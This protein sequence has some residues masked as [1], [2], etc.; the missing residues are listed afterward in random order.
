MVHTSADS[1]TELLLSTRQNPS[2]M[3]S[4]PAEKQNMQLTFLEAKVPLT[5]S[6]KQ[7]PDG[8]YK[9]GGYPG[10]TNFTS[11]T[12]T[13]ESA[14]DFA[15]ALKTHA[16]SGHCLLTNSLT[17]PIVQSSRAKLS[18]KEELREWIVLDIDGID[19]I[20]E[21]DHFI[22]K[23]LPPQFHQTSYVVQ[24]SPSSGIKSG[25]RAHLF[26][27]LS[28]QVDVRSVSAWLKYIN[29]ETKLLSDQVTL[30]NNSMALSLKLDWVAN[31]N[32]RILYITPPVCEGFSD[33]V[34]ERIELVEKK[35][36][37]LSFNFAAI[38]S[39]QMRAKYK[40][41][42]STLRRAAGLTVSKKEEYYILRN[43]KEYVID[44][45]V[46]PA[47]ITDPVQDNDLF[48][49]CNLD[50]G[51]SLAYYYHR[52]NPAY[53]YNFKGEPAVRMKLCDPE[54]YARVALPDSEA[55]AA[56][57]NRPFVFRDNATDK[58]FAGIRK[59][60]QIIKQPM[61]VGSQ[62]KLEHYFMHF[63]QTPPPDPI[64]TWDLMFD[65]TL[66]QQWNEAERVFNTW[67][68][69]EYQLN[70]MYRTN[71][72]AVINKVLVHVTGDDKEAYH[73]FVNWL[74]YIYQNRDKSGTAWVLHG[75]PGTGKG[76]LF[77]NI[78]RPLFGHDYCQTKQVRDLK[79]KFNG[80]MEKALFVNV[81]ETNSE[82]AGH[83][84][85]EI[86]NALKQW[87]TDPFMSVRHMQSTA[88]N[89]RSF[90][91]FIFTTNDFGVLPIQDGDRRFSVAPRQ[92]V[93]ISLSSEEIGQ[94]GTELLDFAGYLQSYEV[95]ELMARTPLVNEAK[96]DLKLAAESS[97]DAFFRAAREGDLEF[98]TAG[99]HETMDK[100]YQEMSNFQTA[101]SQW[102]DD[103]KHGRPSQVGELQ[104]RDAHV[105]MCRDKGMKAGAFR[106]MCAHKGFASKRQAP[107]SSDR[108]QGWTIEWKVSEAAKKGLRIHL[109][110]VK[111]DQ[112]IES[113][114]E[115]EI[116]SEK[117]E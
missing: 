26:F 117:A 30:S 55:L 73:H 33:P 22:T 18:D 103:V 44:S 15:T 77:N 40:E 28:D 65:P 104:L 2:T 113:E 115:A 74:A 81:D 29:L 52:N 53:L 85:K 57:N 16:G 62:L 87:I 84:A 31:N 1:L 96:E 39:A 98:F 8:S 24:H 63:G 109:K 46:E 83:E 64:P 17:Q 66:D 91:N 34:A 79:D 90:I 88:L 70:A 86:V 21:I 58:W 71:I 43:D 61:A 106:K 36:D 12:E 51:D 60:E 116:N 80:W 38:G 72:P 20:T 25:V 7:N 102:I 47:R 112:E 6:Y 49:R 76:V 89:L 23:C 59:E 45:L 105:V 94:I 110:S 95:D 100:H 114:I 3:N 13:V 75:V 27:L 5:K 111:T 69:S 9:G 93:P 14:A 10:V 97:I 56:K 101:V 37:R 68:P 4:H 41:R 99:T 35:Y 19:G 11:M 54:F 42:L 50:G 108:F 67:R 78:I 32:G 107:D 92:T 82:D 48:M